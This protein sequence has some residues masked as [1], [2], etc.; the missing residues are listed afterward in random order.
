MSGAV[1]L[2]RFA[3]RGVTRHARRSLLTG[4]ALAGGIVVLTVL[5]GLQDGYVASRLQDGLLLQLG[6]LRIIGGERPLPDPVALADAFVVDGTALAAA[7]RLRQPAF[8]TCAGG[9][10]G[11]L[12][13]GVDPER[14][15]RV[16]RLT[17]LVG[18]G[19]FLPE[20]SGPPPIVLGRALAQKLGA[21]IGSR[22]TLFVRRGGGL[23]KMSVQVSGL[24][25]TG[26]GLGES[27]LAVVRREALA[28][29]LERPDGADEVA[30]RLADPWQA[31]PL[32][33]SLAARPEFAGLGVESWREMAP[34]IAQAMEL[35]GAIERVRTTVLFALVALGIYTSQSLAL[36]ARRHEFGMLLALGMSPARLL[37]ALTLELLLVAAAAVVAG[38]ALAAGLIAWLNARGLD[39]SAFG[40]R[41]NGALEGSTIVRP[42]FSAHR[43]GNAA[44]WAAAVAFL[45]LLVPAARLLRLDP[46][47]VLR[48][49]E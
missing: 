6:H 1:M 26:G 35:L 5:G 47:T 37:V 20:G 4:A 27:A 14:E 44:L 12:V 13:L 15:A 49:R 33:A 21:T 31:P 34:E 46:A 29:L 3:Q 36:A 45:V 8:L 48:E 7:P 9:S 10:E 30:L 22:V 17:S 25:D 19:A 40:A 11:A 38:V 43:A 42:L 28:L 23:G 2:L 39:L 32:A 24:L 18:D 16:T 41:L